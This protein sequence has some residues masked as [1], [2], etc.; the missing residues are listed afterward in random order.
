MLAVYVGFVAS[1]SAMQA[2][3]GPAGKLFAVSNSHINKICQ[4]HLG[5]IW[6]A[7][8]YG[9]TRFDGSETVTFTRTS[10]AGSLLC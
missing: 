8:D 4:D 5:Y 7:T 9:L 3:A 10:E 1:A 6:L 2:P